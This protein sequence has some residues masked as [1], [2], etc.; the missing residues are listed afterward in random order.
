MRGS[1]Q[2]AAAGDDLV[3]T[4]RQVGQD[5]AIDDGKAMSDASRLAD[6]ICGLRVKA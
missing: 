3:C 5:T 4:N 2:P 1:E 6:D